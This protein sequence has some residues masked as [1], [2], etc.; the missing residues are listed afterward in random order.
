VVKTEGTVKEENRKGWEV[1][2]LICDK[3][4]LKEKWVRVIAGEKREW[5]EMVG[6]FWLIDG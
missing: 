1:L 4:D 2:A 3:F 5:G 6:G